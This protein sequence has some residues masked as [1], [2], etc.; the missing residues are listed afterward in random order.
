MHLAKEGEWRN[1]FL[2]P[3]EK[4]GEIIAGE[5]CLLSESLCDDTD[6]IS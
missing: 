3:L 2:K 5:Y 1:D 6:Q 4:F